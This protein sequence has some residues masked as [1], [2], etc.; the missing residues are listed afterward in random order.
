MININDDINIY[1]PLKLK[2][3]KQQIDALN[4]CK[5]SINNGKKYILLNAPT[6]SG[7][8]YFNIMFINWYK[9]F[10]N[11]EAKFDIL[12]NSKILQDQYT[13]DFDFIKDLKGMSNYRCFEHNTNCS[14]GKEIN[15][16]LK[17]KCDRCPYDYAKLK[18]M[19][20]DIGISNFALFISMSLYTENIIKKESNVLIIDESHDFESV[21]CN[22][23]STKLNKNTLKKCGFPQTSFIKFDRI[24]KKIKTPDDFI[25][26]IENDFINNIQNIYD[27]HT[28]KVKNENDKNIRTLQRKQIL[29]CSKLLERLDNLIDTYYKNKNNWTLDISYDK[30]KDIDINLQPIWGYPYLKK[31]IWDNYD[32]IIF[33]SGTLLNKNMF[34][35]INGIEPELTTYMEMDSVFNVKK[36]PLYYMKIGKMTYKE[37]SKTFDNQVDVINKILKKYKNDKGIIHTFNYEIVDWI[38]NKIKDK[39]LIFH[40]SDDRD[41]MYSITINDEWY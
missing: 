4:F 3:R 41:K 12:T 8:S 11:S 13:K 37:K 17:R 21:F 29:Y 31:I 14:E 30:N 7:K 33:M 23:I 27:N 2:P 5:K 26:F 19:E 9:N 38:K 15:K 28:K 10:I 22:F 24:F 20:A 34:S 39:R 18:W 40:N 35:Y 1:F 6:G 32:H 16:I 36:R 25:K